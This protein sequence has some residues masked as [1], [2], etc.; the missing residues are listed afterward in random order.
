MYY[1]YQ[2]FVYMCQY[3]TARR[4]MKDIDEIMLKC[5]T[6]NKPTYVKFGWAYQTFGENPLTKMFDSP[7]QRKV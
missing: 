7:T 2:Y 1:R 3:I 6:R 5:T 4:I